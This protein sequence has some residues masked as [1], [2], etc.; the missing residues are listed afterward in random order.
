MF[1]RYLETM[2]ANAAVRRF[3]PVFQLSAAYL[4]AGIALRLMLWWRFGRESDVVSMNLLWILPA[5]TANDLLQCLYLSIP[6]TLYLLLV[7]DRFYRTL[8][9]RVVL[10]VGF[11]STIAGL[12]FITAAEYFF[13]EEFDARF[14]LVAFDYLMYPT[15]VI[16]DIRAEYPLGW[17]IAVAAAVGALAFF[18]L[19]RFLFAST[20]APVRFA[21]RLQ[22]AVVMLVAA[23]AGL[24]FVNTDS[25]GA[26]SNRVA[27]ELAANGAS[28]FFRA[29][30][31]SELLYPAYYATRDSRQNF[32]VL[33][34]FLGDRGGKLTQ[35]RQG[36]LNR[37][38]PAD[39]NGLGKLNVVVIAEE[40][41]GAE[42]SKLYG[43]ENDLTPHFDSYA[44]QAMWFRHMYASGTRTVRGL[45]AIAA[46]FP[47]IPS[48]SILRRPK[49]EGI[50]TWGSVMSK[51][52]YDTS[53]IYGGYGYFDNM[54]YF[55]G[56]NGF[57]VIDRTDISQVRYENIWGVSDEDLFDRALTY[58]DDR[59]ASGQPFF[60][61]VMTTSNHKPFTFREGV[62]GVPPTGGGRA[63]GVRYADFALGYFMEQAKKRPWFDNT[64]FVVV[65]DHGARVYGKADIPLRTYEIPMMVYAPK[66]V[67]PRMI[68]T[69]TS[70][71]DIAPT[72][73]GLLGL[74]Y[75]APFFGSNVLACE[76]CERIALFSHNHDVAV[77]RDGKLTVL[78]L[79][80][81]EQTLTYNRTE[82]RYTSIPSDGDLA[83]LTVAI[84][85]TA[86]EQFQARQYR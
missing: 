78:G 20:N 80:K 77:Y 26:S 8:A 25:L 86:Y 53:F 7:P 38:F 83:D 31:T 14:N 15:E 6:L 12:C 21:K 29:A 75:E 18:L 10:S 22:P 41:F 79:G 84:Y 85:Q 73:L 47:P 58:F 17:V 3:L 30:H 69:L 67:K 11:V 4:V 39:P 68:E 65:A 82:D 2:H 32:A 71:I 72:V 23:G 42:F 55:F 50:A 70:Q 45:E 43:S 51:Q 35:L 9:S 59:G 48:V 81:S 44:K 1:A 61:I 5:G 60:S 66:H 57:K 56:N 76:L 36:K 19:R 52:G 37:H 62:P 16:G 13:F 28:S 27:N 24:F 74:E 49:N 33:T 46:S 54:N 64:V 40:A 34:R 63:A